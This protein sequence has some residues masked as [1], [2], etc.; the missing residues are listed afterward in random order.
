LSSANFEK[1]T[2][3]TRTPAMPQAAD[4]G[5][6]LLLAEDEPALAEMLTELLTAEGYA[7][8]MARDGHAAW[9]VA[10]TSQHE[11][12]VLDRGLPY[13]DGLTVLRRLR[14]AGWSIPVLVLSAF[15][16]PGDLAAG[17][18][19][20]ADDYLIKPFDID[21]LLARLV[22]LLARRGD[23]TRARHLGDGATHRSHRPARD[24]T[25]L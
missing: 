3:M 25:V 6:R 16:T 19:A 5:R 8:E 20:G 22:S 13:L 24:P 18:E 12:A 14:N 21:D 11:V 17:L 7:V 15:G 4:A 23:P 1:V 2:A 9:H 10:V